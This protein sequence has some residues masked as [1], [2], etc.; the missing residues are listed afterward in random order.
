M[1]ENKLR[2]IAKTKGIKNYESMSKEELLSVIDNLKSITEN[3]LENGLEKITEMNNFSQN[4]L[5]QIMIARHRVKIIIK[6]SLTN[7]III[8]NFSKEVIKNIRRKFCFIEGANKYLKKL[9]KKE[10]EKK[11]SLTKKSKRKN[12]IPK[13][14]KR[15]KSV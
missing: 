7:L 13:N 10:L 5:K 3:L 9:E 8:N 12:I 2:I 14:Y 4:K 6:K 11:D 15:L 1:T